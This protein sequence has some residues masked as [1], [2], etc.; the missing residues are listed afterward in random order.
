VNTEA[1]DVTQLLIDWREGDEE[2][3]ARLKPLV[4]AQVRGLMREFF[5]RK[6]S[7]GR[8]QGTALARE[9]YIRMVDDS[10]V[11]WIDRA[12]FYRIAARSVRQILTEQDGDQTAE[13]VDLVRLNGV[14]TEFAQDY[15]RKSEIVELRF[16]GGLDHQAIAEI[17][18]IPEKTILRDW[19]FAKLWLYRA[20]NHAV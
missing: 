18:Q 16:F 12:Q 1:H 19:N 5:E 17:L 13:E 6:R 3:P 2:A 8:Q 7:G 20:L 10:R 15:P 14:L 11:S 9:V 4:D